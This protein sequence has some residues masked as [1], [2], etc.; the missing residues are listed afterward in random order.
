M[1]QNNSTRVIKTA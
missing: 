1:S